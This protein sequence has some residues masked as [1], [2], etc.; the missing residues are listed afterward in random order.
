M[1]TIVFACGKGGVGKTTSALLLATELA[2]VYPVTLVDADPNQ[3]IKFWATS[4]N[5]PQALTITSDVTEH[6]I[7]EVIEDAAA[8]T[9]V[10]LALARANHHV[11]L[12]KGDLISA[13]T[14]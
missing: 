14:G 4:G 7:N 3:P 12:A 11:T 8:T 13:T 6:N 1:P 9:D 2:K 5:T 10:E